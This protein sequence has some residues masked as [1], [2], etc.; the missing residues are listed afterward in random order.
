[1]P[2]TALGLWSLAAPSAAGI[3]KPE[4]FSMR[5]NPMLEKQLKDKGIKDTRVLEAFGAIPR[6]LF[7]PEEFQN[8]AYEDRPLPI[9]HSQTISQP[10]I[11]AYMTEALQIESTQKILEVGAG[12]GYQ[13]AVLAKLARSVYTLEIVEP[14]YRQAKEALSHLQISN[15]FLRLANGWQG[16]PE[17]APFDKIIVTAAA[18]RPPRELF[19]QLKDGGLIIFP[20]GPQEDVQTLVLGKKIEGEVKTKALLPVRFVPFIHDKND[21]E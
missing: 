5:P 6:H 13:A 9:G 21:S 20:L 10:Y 2:L 18:A 19:A 12:S 17:E 8:S 1:M 4:I 16:W 3:L 7:V 15:V 11:A 14:L